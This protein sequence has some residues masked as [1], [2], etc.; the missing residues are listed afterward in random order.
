MLTLKLLPYK[1]KVFFVTFFLPMLLCLA[2]VNSID[3]IAM[4][5]ISVFIAYCLKLYNQNDPINIKQILILFLSLILM[6]ISKG[7]G[8]IFMSLIILILPFKKIIKENK[9]YILYIVLTIILILGLLIAKTY[10]TQIHN[11][12]DSRAYGSNSQEQLK[13]IINNPISFSKTL[14][15]HTIATFGNLDAMSFLNAPMFFG[16]FYYHVF[17]MILYF[18]IFIGLSDNS[19]SFNLRTKSIFALTF[20]A[21]FITT[22]TALY[23][24]Y[25]AVGANYIDGYQL[26]YIFPIIPLFLMS[27]SIKNMKYNE[28]KCEDILFITYIIGLINILSIIGILTQ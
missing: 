9:K 17:L 24:S 1:K 26:R 25:T 10:S 12:G 3:G 28:N 16:M 22:S 4:G 23:L 13:F 7:I 15:N 8:Y 27:I 11:Y 20:F 14:I 5:L 21:I 6:S 2:S 19:K 18:I